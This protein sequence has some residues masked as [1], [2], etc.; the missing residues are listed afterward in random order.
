LKRAVAEVLVAVCTVLGVVV[1]ASKLAPATAPSRHEATPHE[2]VQD[3]S[4]AEVV[5]GPKRCIV[6]AST[7]SDRLIVELVGADAL[8][9]VATPERCERPWCAAIRGKARV[10]SLDDLETLARLKPDLVVTANPGAPARLLRLREAGLPVFDL[11][12]S[13]GMRS[14]EAAT[15]ALGRVLAAEPVAAAYWARFSRRMRTVATPVDARPRALYLAIYGSTLVGGARDTSWHDVIEA[16]GLRDAADDRS[17]WPSW[18][19][20][21]V[22]ER[23]PS[24]LV[25]E[26]GMGARL[27]ARE[28]L[29]RTEACARGQVAEIDAD[30]LGDPG[31]TML[32]AA[33]AL[34]NRVAELS[35][36][37]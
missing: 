10:T 36:R 37:R 31:P 28:G 7:V 32:E 26:H 35:A 22:A 24:F 33:E 16:A 34:A 15:Y 13:T 27:C 29:A 11:G 4:G 2:R 9:A 6:S 19:A 8:C 25:T 5:R 20:V 30:L 18:S 14:L 17:G 23:N 12:P 21:D 3:A 1:G